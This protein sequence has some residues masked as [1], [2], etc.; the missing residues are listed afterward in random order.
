MIVVLFESEEL[1]SIVSGSFKLVI[2][3][4][5]IW[6]DSARYHRDI[7]L[8]HY[9]L[10]I[11]L[12]VLPVSVFYAWH[13]SVPDMLRV[14]DS[15]GKILKFIEGASHDFIQSQFIFIC[16]TMVIGF[17]LKRSENVRYFGVAIDF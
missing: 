3:F 15:I 13:A 12:V 5:A 1:F 14:T 2:C 11:E 8:G 7:L 6:V 17:S 9:S 16:C 4:E 10:L